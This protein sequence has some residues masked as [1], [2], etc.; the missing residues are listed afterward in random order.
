MSRTWLSNFTFTFHFHALEKEMATHSSVLAWRIPGRGEPGGLPSMGSH[1]VRH[2][3]SDLA[4][5][6]AYTLSSWTKDL[7]NINSFKL[8]QPPAYH[9]GIQWWIRT[10]VWETKSYKLGVLNLGCT[11]DELGRFK[12]GVI[13]LWPASQIQPTTSFWMALKLR[14]VFTF[15][16]A[17][18]KWEDYFKHLQ[19]IWNAN[20]SVHK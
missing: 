8:H 15:L 7:E 20:F 13:E 1:T 6:A 10:T 9:I 4:A 3:W 11:Q 16:N 14:K 19:I 12:T 5:A 17:L 2:N 18:K